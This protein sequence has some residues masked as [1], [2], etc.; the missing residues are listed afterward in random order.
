[1]YLTYIATTNIF[2]MAPVLYQNGRINMRHYNTN[3][4]YSSGKDLQG[5]MLFLICLY[6]LMLVSLCNTLL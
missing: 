6:V 1:M 5:H 2:L 4:L 3:Q